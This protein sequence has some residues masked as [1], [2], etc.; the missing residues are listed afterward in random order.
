[1]EDEVVEGV[2]GLEMKMEM[3]VIVAIMMMVLVTV[4]VT[5]MVKMT[6]KTMRTE[7]MTPTAAA[8]AAA[9][10]A[11]AAPAATTSTHQTCLLVGLDIFFKKNLIVNIADRYTNSSLLTVHRV[12]TF[13]HAS[14]KGQQLKSPNVGQNRKH[15]GAAVS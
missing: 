2:V 4:L 15:K 1:M 10:A 7:V 12:T 3:E 11:A 8:A 6:T 13:W 14:R 9:V 5:M